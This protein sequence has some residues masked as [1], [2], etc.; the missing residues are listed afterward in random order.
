MRQH[1]IDCGLHRAVPQDIVEVGA[2]EVGDADRT[3]LAGLVRL[4]QS[5]PR[6]QVAGVK[7]ACVAELG[8]RLRAVD[9]HQIDVIER[10]RLK[11]AVDTVLRIGVAFGLCNEL[12]GDEK[13]VPRN[14][15]RTQALADAALVFKSLGRVEVAVADRCGIANDMCDRGVINPPGAE[16][17][18]RDHDAIGKGEG[19]VEDH[20]SFLRPAGCS[21]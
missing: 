15:A 7:V 9:Q 12:G 13:L 2:F 6:L 17:Q 4:F 19:F 11:R 5:A 8:P 20:C 1:L 10:E 14:A 21:P 18:L 3:E 16:T